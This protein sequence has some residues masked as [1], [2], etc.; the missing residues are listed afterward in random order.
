M[1][2]GKQPLRLTVNGAHRQHMKYRAVKQA[3][4][5]LSALVEA[6]DAGSKIRAQS[7]PPPGLVNKTTLHQS[8]PCSVPR[9]R[10][11]IKAIWRCFHRPSLATR[12][13]LHSALGASIFAC[14]L[15]HQFN[16]ASFGRTG[17]HGL[18]WHL[19]LRSCHLKPLFTK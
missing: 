10:S 7:P 19:E 15:Q 8:V 11:S 2:C 3:P 13:S 1:E 18:P 16:S 9:A 14:V 17:R 12:R 6:S 5:H 4:E